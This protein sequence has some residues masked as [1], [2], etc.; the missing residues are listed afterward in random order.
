MHTADA[1]WLITGAGGM[2]A[3]DFTRTLESSGA[4]VRALPRKALDITDVSDVERAMAGVD[5]V[6]NCAGHTAVD[7]AENNADAAF[8]VNAHG[9]GI[10]ARACASAGVKLIQI[11]TD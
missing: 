11:S 4:R 2:L 3:D 1:A 10:L 8:R 6:V 9:A 7:A 5:I